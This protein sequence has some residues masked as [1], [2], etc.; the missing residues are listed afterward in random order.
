MAKWQKICFHY[1]QTPI[2][3]VT[4][5]NYMRCIITK[6]AFS[7]CKNKGTD[8]LHRNR[9][10]DQHLCFHYIDS[11]IPLIP[12]FEISRLQAFSVIVHSGLC[13]TWSETH[14]IGFFKMRL[15]C[16]T[17][18]LHELTRKHRKAMRYM[19]TNTECR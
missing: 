18:Q 11:I 10:A 16:H 6:P 7:I 12:N 3:S 13:Q 8:Q 1:H 14:K 5:N 15:I 17:Q 9:A 4:L 2:L 19:I